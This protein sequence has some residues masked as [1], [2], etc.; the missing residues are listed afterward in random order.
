MRRP[1]DRQRQRHGKHDR[2]RS[3]AG[4][5]RQDNDQRSKRPARSSTLAR[6]LRPVGIGGEERRRDDAQE[7]RRGQDHGDLLG[8]EAVGLEP[9]REIRQMIPIDT[10]SDAKINADAQ[11]RNSAA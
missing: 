1:D 3:A 10:K 11:L 7:H 9:E 2:R 8:I 5:N 4:N 6:S